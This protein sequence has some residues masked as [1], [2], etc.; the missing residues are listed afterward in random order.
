MTTAE[1]TYEEIESLDYE[2]YDNEAHIY[3]TDPRLIDIN[4]DDG[5]TLNTYYF[6]PI[7]NTTG[8]YDYTRDR[9]NI[10]TYTLELPPIQGPFKYPLLLDAG[11]TFYPDG[12]FLLPDA[13]V[14]F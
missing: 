9:W 1:F 3:P 8:T 11:Y 6:D 13:S 12:S 2:E 14:P 10:W 7:D 4:Y 5:W